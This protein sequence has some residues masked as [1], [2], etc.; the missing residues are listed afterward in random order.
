MS[1]PKRVKARKTSSRVAPRLFDLRLATDDPAPVYQQLVDQLRLLVNTGELRPG[2]RLPSARHLAANLGVNRNTAL[3]AYLVLAREGLLEGRRG[4]GTVVIGPA[5]DA[6]ARVRMPP[7]LAAQVGQ[8]V[9][10]ANDLGVPSS[11]LLAFISRHVDVRARRSD[12]RV[13]FVECNP[14][15]LEHYVGRIRDEFGVAMRP[16]LLSGVTDASRKGLLRDV[17]C[18][19]STFFHLS[20]I[21]RTLREASVDAELF[22]IAVRPHLSVIEALE[23]LA[24]RSSVGVMYYERPGDLFAAAR[25]Q[26]MADAV[27]HTGVRELHVRPVLL[28]G[29]LRP[30]DI[31]GLDALVVRPENVAPIRQKLPRSLPVIEFINDLDAASRQFLGEMFDDI[32]VRR[33]AGAAHGRVARGGRT[34]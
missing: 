6:R 15:S 5:P 26:R 10:A 28:R 29:S 19:V 11:D 22:A 9:A 7:Q 16:L 31:D 18:I 17:D 3:R 23:R 24:R 2:A 20:E 14:E 30:R 32:A 12:L 13:V 27:A 4:G 8:L 1:Q 25:L 21:R 33:A 34:A